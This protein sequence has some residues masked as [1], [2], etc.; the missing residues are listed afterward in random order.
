MPPRVE[1][2]IAAMDSYKEHAE[3]AME[4]TA[5]EQLSSYPLLQQELMKISEMLKNM[6][7][8]RCKLQ[9]KHLQGYEINRA[10]DPVVVE[11][12]RF[13]MQE[14]GSV[15]ANV[16]KAFHQVSDAM[17]GD[18]RLEVETGICDFITCVTI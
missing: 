2:L 5:N 18:C 7:T 15:A 17:P 4:L 10:D 16:E 9:E 1:H 14:Y 3:R 12:S 13:I 8:C 11:Y 6:E